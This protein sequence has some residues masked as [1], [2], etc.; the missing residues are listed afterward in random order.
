MLNSDLPLVTHYLIWSSLMMLGSDSEAR[1]PV[2]SVGLRPTVDETQV[3]YLGWEDPLEKEMATHSNILAWRI[4]WTEKPGRLQSM[5]SKRVRY[6]WVTN[7]LS[8]VSGLLG[9][10]HI[11]TVVNNAAIKMDVQIISW[12]SAFSALGCIPGRE[13]AASYVNSIFNFF[14]NCH[15]I[16][17]SC[18]TILYFYQQCTRLP[19][20]PHP[21]QHLCFSGGF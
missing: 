15:V 10:F 18:C 5:G 13:I 19:I 9:Y 21:P 16:I 3:R 17:C 14:K 8:S 7:T 1:L 12:R 4:P 6:Y 2:S 20:S 11:L